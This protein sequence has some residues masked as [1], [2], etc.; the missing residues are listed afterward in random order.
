[1]DA[2][3]QV[4]IAAQAYGQGPEHDLFEPMVKQVH[5]NLKVTKKQKQRTIIAADSGY[6]TKDTLAYIE[7][8]K[9]DAYVADPGFRSRDP[10]FKDYKEHKPKGR[11]KNKFKA[12]DFKVDLKKQTCVCP[13]G[14]S[15]WLKATKANIKDYQFLQFQAYEADCPICPL[16][17]QCLR[18]KNQK[19]PRQL[20]IKQGS[21]TELKNSV[22]EKMKRKIDSVKGRHD[23]SKRLGIVEPVFGNINTM[24][25]FKWFSLRGK[26]KVNAQWQFISMVH[27]MLKIHRYGWQG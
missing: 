1:M 12:G 6:H 10:R 25:G 3:H 16:K 18:Q 17:T 5:D 9:L 24:I 26:S 4:I 2:K 7:E 22:I 8:N 21:K 23:Y 11:L 27:N 20:N 15:M 14:K 13:A 19:T